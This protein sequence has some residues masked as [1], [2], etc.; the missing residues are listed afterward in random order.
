[1]N[2]IL[3]V[4]VD[5]GTP[6]AVSEDRYVNEFHAAP[7]P[8]GKRLAFVA[9]GAASYQWWRRSSSHLDQSE[10]WLLDLS[11]PA[12]SATAYTQLTKRDARQLWPMWS[13]DGR[14]LFYVAD[15]A[16][17]EN[18]WSRPASPDRR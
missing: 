15:R 7:S 13:A 8:D 9:R 2:D 4:A 3:R 17:A 6:M 18:V 12:N 10:L 5:G 11:A 14:A 1:M 16:G